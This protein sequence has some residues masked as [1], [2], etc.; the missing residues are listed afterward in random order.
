MLIIRL[1]AN[2]EGETRLNRATETEII[3]LLF[4]RIIWRLNFFAR[5]LRRSIA[6]VD[7]P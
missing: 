6:N 5:R 4:I 7:S 2:R 1:F 3:Q